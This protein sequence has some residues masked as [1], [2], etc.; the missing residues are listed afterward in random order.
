[1]QSETLGGLQAT[2]PNQAT[3]D[4]QLVADAALVQ[5][6]RQ[7]LHDMVCGNT[8]STRILGL[9]CAS[10]G[11]ERYLSYTI[12]T[13][14]KQ[15]TAAGRC[16]DIVVGLNNGFS[17]P[18]VI[19]QF[20]KLA[21]VEVVELYTGDK[22]GPD[23]IAVSFARPEQQTEPALLRNAAQG[24]HRIVVVHQRRSP[25]AAGKIRMLSDILHGLVIPSIARGW[26]LP[27]YTLAFDAESMFI[28][29][30][31]ERSLSRELAKVALL[32]ER[33]AGATEQIVQ[34]LLRAH[35]A[36]A[37]NT[38]P[39]P[40][41]RPNLEGTDD[42]L[43]RLIRALDSHPTLD[44]VGATTRFCIYGEQRVLAGVPVCLPSF[45]EPCSAMHTMYNYVCGL[46]PGCLCLPG[47]GTLGR[48]D[49]VIALLA[50]IASLYSG[51]T[52]EDSF[53]TTLAQKLGWQMQLRDDVLL[54]NRCPRESEVVGQPPQLAWQRQFCRWYAG[55]D[56]VE[57][58]YGR[59]NAGLVVGPSGDDFYTAS[60]AIFAKLL[61]H[62]GDGASSL[63]LL[64]R[65]LGCGDDYNTI[66][67][68]AD[69]HAD[70][71]V[72]EHG[73]PAW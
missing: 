22:P 61:G 68:L 5:G 43:G 52:A 21:T 42:G 33:C 56:S 2:L 60:L 1:M 65:F 70:V 57:Q 13:I 34:M 45:D 25:Y 14:L 6:C 17:C 67:Q 37:R 15:I 38:P 30:D 55:F 8:D 35:Y 40:L 23:S 63:A 62:G 20:R 71:L 51:A 69:A 49:C 26:A 27:C 53:L 47:G 73:R 50:T 3:Q 28:A 66:R 72:G 41:P 54:T 31:T 29:N 12:P 11:A 19:D 10:A 7:R 58:L 18:A 24:R 4:Q 36:S 44:L 46:L 16:A 32:R 39:P 64:Q 9:L 48:S 59:H